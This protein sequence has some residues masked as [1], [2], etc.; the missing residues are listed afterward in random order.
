M[1]SKQG[2][3]CVQLTGIVSLDSSIEVSLIHSGS[4]GILFS[5]RKFDGSQSDSYGAAQA[6]LQAS[7]SSVCHYFCVC[8]N[9]NQT[10]TSDSAL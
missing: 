3:D 2:Q 7:A 4:N 1:F 6:A 10:R 8:Y 5:P 9:A